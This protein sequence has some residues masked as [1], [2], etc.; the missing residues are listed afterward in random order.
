MKMFAISDSVEGK[1]AAAPMPMNARAAISW[2]GV[3]ASAPPRLPVAKTARPASRTP[4]RPK[5]SLRLP[6]ARMRD[7]NTRL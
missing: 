1:I 6:A 5:R 7:A 2:L 3:D 4:L